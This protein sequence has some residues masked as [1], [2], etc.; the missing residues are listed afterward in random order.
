MSRSG[1]AG[2]RRRRLGALSL[3]A[4]ALALLLLA[5]WIFAGSV[6]GLALAAFGLPTLLAVATLLWREKTLRHRADVSPAPQQ[7]VPVPPSALPE[8]PSQAGPAA[9]AGAQPARDDA[10]TALLA[11]MERELRKPLQALLDAA[12]ALQATR[13]D[14]DQR[15][16]LQSLRGSADALQALLAGMLDFARSESG[17]LALAREPFVLAQLLQRLVQAHAPGAADK[18]VVLD[19]APLPEGVPPLLGDA[20]RLE[21]LL[22]ALVDNAIRHAAAGRVGVAV[23][24]SGRDAGQVRLHFT[25]TDTGSGIAPQRLEGLFQPGIWADAAPG[26]HGDVRLGLA[27]ARA[28]ATLMGG[29]IGV[30]SQPGMGSEFWFTVALDVAAEPAAASAAGSGDSPGAAAGAVGATPAVPAPRPQRLAGLRLLVV[31]DGLVNREVAC[32]LLAAEG[33]QCDAAE[34]GL[35]ALEMLLAEAGGPRPFDAM[36]LD[37]Q[38][39]VLDGLETARRL[40]ADPAL[41]GLPVIALSAGVLPHQQQAALDA[42]MDEFMAKPIQLEAMV[43]ALRRHLGTRMPAVP[44]LPPGAPAAAAAAAH[45]EALP[46]VPGVDHADAARRLLGNRQ[47]FLGMLRTLRDEFGAT[48]ARSRADV[49][50]GDMASAAGRLHRLHGL[51][52]NLSA[53]AVAAAAGRAEAALRDGED[54]AVEPA[55]RAL[56]Q[57]LDEMLAGLPPEV[58]RPWDDAATVPRDAA[59]QDDAATIGAL[60]AALAE[61]DMG[62]FQQYHALRATLAER[63][64]HEAVDRLDEAMDQLRFAEAI[65]LLRTWYPRS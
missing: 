19:L 12:Q 4:L 28:L 36:F 13:L 49:A 23:R 37:V 7:P 11:G 3:A 47:L 39:P 27:L 2:A 5:A 54:G 21:Q 42:G 35:Q 30:R 33:A 50:R 18:G 53:H 52:G 44:A 56:E 29:D 62:V 61:G 59:A 41:A 24:M 58:E 1:R 9:A 38:M 6:G 10:G 22:S 63:H 20:P 16:L 26:R 8:A 65:A 60:L 51:A 17:T 25:V 57:A 40:R 43:A 46:A 32:R 15:H 34:H 48:P 45:G 31:D 14:A 55:L 64:G